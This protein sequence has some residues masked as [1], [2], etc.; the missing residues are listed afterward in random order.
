MQELSIAIH[1]CPTRA[2]R[3]GYVNRALPD[4][5]L[6]NFVDALA[7]RIASF[8]RRAIAAAKHLIKRVSLP[9]ADQLLDAITSFETALTWPEAQRRIQNLLARGL[10]REVDF[11]KSVARRARHAPRRD[12]AETTLTEGDNIMARN[13]TAKRRVPPS[14]LRLIWPRKTSETSTAHFTAHLKMATR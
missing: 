10:Q 12:R 3:Y 1:G 5:E 13:E 14:E 6:D 9:S 8:D 7:R 11:E 4:A 2:E